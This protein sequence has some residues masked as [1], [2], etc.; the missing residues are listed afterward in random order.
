VS[1]DGLDGRPILLTGANGG[2]GL[3]LTDYLLESE[4]SPLV[5]QYRTESDALF[6]TV[7]KH[8]LDP[9]R[10]CIRAD[11]A[12]EDDV[13][14]LGARVA[15]D[16]GPIW[17]LINL[18]GSTSNGVAWKLSLDEFQRVMLD[19]L[20]TT[21]LVC[22]EF[23]P[24]MREAEGGRIVNISSVVAFSGAP[25]A[26]HYAAAKA[27][28]VGYTKSIARELASRRVTANVLALGYFDYGMLYTVPETLREGI[29]QEIPAGRFGSASEIGGMLSHLLS[30][31]SAYTTGQVLHIN[32]GLYA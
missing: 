18:A 7:R 32:G 21:F 10:H 4:Q 16:F 24:A 31:H 5:C 8:G 3:A 27:G 25:G 15:T 22:R 26:S 12:N 23:I 1:V 19:S 14:E 11:L 20:T 17:G 28:I 13:R 30:E 2:I 6:E 9:K 29:R